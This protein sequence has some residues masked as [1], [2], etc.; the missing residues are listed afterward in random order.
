MEQST[1]RLEIYPQRIEENGRVVINAF[2]QHGAQVACVTKAIRAHLAVVDALVASGADMLADSRVSN[3]EALMKH[4]PGQPRLLLRVPTPS[5]AFEVVRSAD[6]SLN[7]SL[8]TLERLSLAAI[9]LHKNHSVIIMI[10]LGDLREGI[11]PANAI[12][13]LRTAIRLAGIN[14][15]GLGCNLACYGGVMPT[16]E[17]MQQLVSIRDTCRRATGLTLDLLSG[18]NSSALSLLYSGEMP[19]EINH[20]RIGESILLGR[21]VLD[22]NPWPGTR[23]D[24]FRLVAEVIELECKPS[25]PVG[26]RGQDAFGN[27]PQFVNRGLRHRAICNIGR[28]DI[29]PEGLIPHNSGII[30]LGASSDH[31]ILDVEDAGERLEVGQEISFSPNYGALLAASTSDYISKVIVMG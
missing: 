7:S 12:S 14:I 9:A 3:L 20:F 27:Q 4:K 29:L 25:L 28:Q 24:T 30:I 23:Q 26:L 18:G 19:A 13:F 1:P 6:Y 5:Q 2:H 8:I 17:N 22:R 21:N 31:L 10:E 16:A 11:Q 15:I